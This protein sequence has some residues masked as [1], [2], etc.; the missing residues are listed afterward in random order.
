MGYSF[1][2]A[3][4]GFLST[5]SPRERI[6]HTTAFVNPN[7]GEEAGIFIIIIVFNFEGGGVWVVVFIII[8]TLPTPH[9]S[10]GCF[11]CMILASVLF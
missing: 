5:H 2:L 9:I 4:N 3:A 1:Q 10:K 6:I 8:I 11:K 7:C